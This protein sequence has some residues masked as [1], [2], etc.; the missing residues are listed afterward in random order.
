[1]QLF[2]DS[3]KMSHKFSQ[4]SYLRRPQAISP[5]PLIPSTIDVTL[6]FQIVTRLNIVN[7]KEQFPRSDETVGLSILGKSSLPT[8]FST[9]NGELASDSSHFTYFFSCY[10][11]MIRL[12]AKFQH[13]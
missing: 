9:F 8:G 13:R 12:L 1:M 2:F 10:N 11:G 6:S 5:P 4:I 3:M 7:E